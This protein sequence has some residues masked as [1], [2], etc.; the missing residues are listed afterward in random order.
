MVPLGLEVVLPNER[1]SGREER[2]EPSRHYCCL[3]TGHPLFLPKCFSLRTLQSLMQLETGLYTMTDC[4]TLYS[5]YGCSL[6]ASLSLGNRANCTLQ[7]AG[8]ADRSE[9]LGAR[10]AR[11]DM[12]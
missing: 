5:L 1:P 6:L 3:F 4:R 2:A 7:A 12:S 8:F 11:V 9:D 10:N